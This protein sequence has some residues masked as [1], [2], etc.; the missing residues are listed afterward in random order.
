MKAKFLSPFVT[1][2]LITLTLTSKA[3]TTEVPFIQLPTGQILVEADLLGQAGKQYFIIETSGTNL[4][5]GDMN[6]RLDLLGIDTTSAFLKFPEIKIGDI[7][8]DHKNNFRIRKALG[9]RSEY[10][11]PPSV[12]G[13]LGPK[14]FGKKVL[15]FNFQKKTLKIADSRDELNLDVNTPYVYFTQSFTNAVPVLDVQSAET[16]DHDV[17]LNVSLAMGINFPVNAMST[18]VQ[19][20]GN[21]ERKT[22][23]LSLD[24]KTNIIYTAIM[25]PS[26]YINKEVT[27]TN[28]ELTFTDELMPAI[29]NSFLQHFLTTIDFNDGILFLD[30]KTDKGKEMMA[31]HTVKPLKK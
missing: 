26:I 4:I 17:Y 5:R 6:Q 16:T 22:Y 13:T 2:L 11:F 15:Q 24:G 31:N 19:Y 21:D 30:P 8:F 27:L 20:A 25:A 7:A 1:C 12:L 3:V 18:V 14:F 9:K 10:A 23:K 29:G 28:V